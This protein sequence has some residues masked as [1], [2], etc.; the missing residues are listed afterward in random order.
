MKH[1]EYLTKKRSNIREKKA[2]SKQYWK[3]WIICARRCGQYWERANKKFPKMFSEKFINVKLMRR[4]HNGEKSCIL[5][6]H[7]ACGYNTC[8][9]PE[10]EE[11]IEYYDE[12]EISNIKKRLYYNVKKRREHTKLCE[13]LVTHN[14]VARI[15]NNIVNG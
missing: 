1:M 3:F 11:H 14:D 4:I 7:Y 13:E 2:D 5:C 8:I 6:N 9:H 10:R 15:L 12:D